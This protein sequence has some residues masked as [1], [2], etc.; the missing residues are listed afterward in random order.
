M[1]YNAI[2]EL[3]VS[4][5]DLTADGFSSFLDPIIRYQGCVEINAHG[6]VQLTITVDA[7]DAIHATR[8]V[9]DLTRVVYPGYRVN[10]VDVLPSSGGTEPVYG[11]GEPYDPF[12]E[13]YDSLG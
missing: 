9:Y 5:D 3:D 11:F 13:P 4:V 7:V 2:I 1:E 6:R 10:C 12:G 8:F